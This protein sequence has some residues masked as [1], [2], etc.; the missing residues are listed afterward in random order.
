MLSDSEHH[1][2]TGHHISISIGTGHHLTSPPRCR[3]FL[4]LLPAPQ[5][6]PPSPHLITTT[7]APLCPGGKL[8]G[9]SLHEPCSSITV[10]HPGSAGDDLAP[11]RK[12]VSR[13]NQNLY[14]KIDKIKSI[15]PAMRLS[16]SSSLI[17]DE[18]RHIYPW[19][20][21]ICLRAQK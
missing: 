10:S 16:R 18:V 7:V 4:L 8:F 17:A 15:L 19:C 6:P 11:Q 1:F 20:V 9:F 2:K 5:T 21:N 13:A 12:I 3:T 14:I